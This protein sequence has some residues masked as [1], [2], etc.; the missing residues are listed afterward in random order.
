MVHATSGEH[1][2]DLLGIDLLASPPPGAGGRPGPVEPSPVEVPSTTAHLQ[3]LDEQQ[4]LQQL[5]KCTV[6]HCPAGEAQQEQE[7]CPPLDQPVAPLTAEQPAQQRQPSLLLQQLDQLELHPLPPQQHLRFSPNALGAE[8][9]D[10]RPHP[11]QLDLRQP[12]EPLLNA[13]FLF[14][15][16]PQDAFLPSYVQNLPLELQGQQQQCVSTLTEGACVACPSPLA[17]ACVGVASDFDRASAD[18]GAASGTLPPVEQQEQP[19]IFGA[20]QASLSPVATAQAPFAATELR[21]VQKRVARPEGHHRLLTLTELIPQRLVDAA[22][23]GDVSAMDALQ[24]LASELEGGTIGLSALVGGSDSEDGDWG[25]DDTG[26]DGSDADFSDDVGRVGQLKCINCT[27]LQRAHPA[28]CEECGHVFEHDASIFAPVLTPAEPVGAAVASPQASGLSTETLPAVLCFDE[29]MTAHAEGA[30]HPHPERPDRIRAVMARLAQQGLLDRVQRVDC[31]EA[32]I[33]ELEACHTPELVAGLQAASQEASKATDGLPTYFT[34][35]TYVNAHTYQC[36]RLSAGGCVQVTSAVARREARCG[37]AVVRPPGHHAESNTAMGFCF[38]NNA[39][40][41]ARAAQAAGARRVL[42]LDW[43]VHHGNGT[44]HIFEEDDSVMYMSLHRYDGGSFYP[45]T[46]AAAEVG[47]G[48]GA[49]YTVNVPWLCGNMHDGDYLAAFNHVLLPIAYEFNPDL[50]IV[51]AGFDAALG[52]PIGG[53]QVSPQGFAHM[54]SLLKGVAPMVVLLE[55]GYNLTA[56]AAS[57][58]ATLRVMLGEAPPALPG[59]RAPSTQGMAAIKQAIAA[60]A[61]HWTCMTLMHNMVAPDPLELAELRAE[62]M[63]AAGV[64]D[65]DDDNEGEGESDYG[66]TPSTSDMEED[67]PAPSHRQ[68]QQQPGEGAS[69]DAVANNLAADADAAAPTAEPPRRRPQRAAAAVA[70]THIATEL[71]KAGAAA[72]PDASGAGAAGQ[73]AGPLAEAV[74]AGAQGPGSARANGHCGGEASSSSD[75]A[76]GSDS[77]TEAD[78]AGSRERG[79][80]AG[81]SPNKVAAAGLQRKR[82]LSATSG[83]DALLAGLSADQLNLLRACKRQKQFTTERKWQLINALHISA[84]RGLLKRQAARKKGGTPTKATKADS[85]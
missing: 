71:A 67:E 57:V 30:R 50:L 85:I 22:F 9:L 7:N 3:L 5:V 15:E 69:A 24:L 23:A 51:S 52:D 45:G 78:S 13:P 34:P 82:S 74:V 48:T 62:A 8:A 65:D 83:V 40:I 11:E 63:A 81:A 26:G 53:C 75:A 54:T 55:G 37:V 33:P 28:Q 2:V 4:P 41:A 18:C 1:P 38:F 31:R 12:S 17:A 27:H 73:E 43:D 46:G 39:A 61:E 56:T 36:A 49:G 64:S 10:Q 47:R 84:L 77:A 19:A 59:R 76:H 42:I 16:R 66:T 14:A 25:V 21:E 44:Q 70:A 20:S 58:E 60:H 68:Q 6:E 80:A 29:R 35:D 32:S 79:G 72:A